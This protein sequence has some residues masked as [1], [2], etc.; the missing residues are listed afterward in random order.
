[1]FA[2]PSVPTTYSLAVL[3][4]LSFN[5]FGRFVNHLI[6]EDIFVKHIKSKISD[7]TWGSVGEFIVFNRTR[8]NYTRKLSDILSNFSVRKR[9]LDG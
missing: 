6:D 9:A 3:A 8:L 7:R 4:W 2:F 1:M 5:D